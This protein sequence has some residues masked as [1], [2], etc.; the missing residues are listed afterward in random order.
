MSGTIN[1]ARGAGDRPC[2][3]R[4]WHFRIHVNG[5]RPLCGLV[6]FICLSPGVSLVPTGRAQ[7]LCWRAL[8]A[9]ANAVKCVAQVVNLRAGRPPQINN[10]RYFSNSFRRFQFAG[11][12]IGTDA[13][14]F[15]SGSRQRGM[16]RTQ[17]N[18][19]LGFLHSFFDHFRNRFAAAVF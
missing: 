14:H 16:S 13:R 3:N 1:R 19:S 15:L 9:L 4:S 2:Q 12:Q 11:E 5:C 10:L 8:R 17:F 7:A 18:F 6:S